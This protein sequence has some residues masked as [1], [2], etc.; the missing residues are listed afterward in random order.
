MKM[1]GYFLVKKDPA[2]GG[3]RVG[4]LNEYSH[5]FSSDEV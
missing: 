4:K 3:V 2:S 5:F 1:G